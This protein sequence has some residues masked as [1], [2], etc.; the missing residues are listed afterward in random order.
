MDETEREQLGKEMLAALESGKGVVSYQMVGPNPGDPGPGGRD[1]PL[2]L[3]GGQHALC[4]VDPA[5]RHRRDP[6]RL[7]AQDRHHTRRQQQELTT[8]SPSI[9]SAFTRRIALSGG[10][11]K[12]AFRTAPWASS[13]RSCGMTW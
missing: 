11:R 2:Y 1:A 13:R 5:E 8:I 7:R 6:D 10:W 9:P 12:T 4:R 3:A